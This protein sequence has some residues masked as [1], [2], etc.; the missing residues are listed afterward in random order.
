MVSVTTKSDQ[1]NGIQG[2]YIPK[3]NKY[4][5]TQQKVLIHKGTKKTF[6][7][8]E[9]KAKMHVPVSTKYETSESMVNKKKSSVERAP[10]R[11]LPD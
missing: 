5:E 7:D 10:R 9:V 11:T 2:Y 4:I 3:F 8:Y 1:I 6:L